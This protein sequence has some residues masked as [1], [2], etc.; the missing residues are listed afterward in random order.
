MG[1]LAVA[2]LALAGPVA[3]AGALGLTLSTGGDGV[4][5]DFTA[6]SN[7]YEVPAQAGSTASC[8][9]PALQQV[10]AAFGDE[11]DYFL[12]PGGAFEGKPAGWSLGSAGVSSGN[13]P[14]YLRSRYDS[15]SLKIPAGETVTSAPI[16]VDLDH[17]SFRMFVRGTIVSDLTGALN[18]T[19][20]LDV[21]VVYADAPGSPTRTV[22]RIHTPSK[23]KVTPDIALLPEL[24]GE[25]PGWR[26]VRLRF[27]APLDT[28]R[29][30]DLYIDP[31]HRG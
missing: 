22:G 26:L 29:I 24:G 7:D 17:P 23:W 14:W 10:F 2:A 19:T 30:D 12:A 21:K 9:R 3:Q 6:A 11:K 5:A 16:C 28:V 27:T 1:L 13:E 18:V 31:R 20:P 4:T 25:D 15:S 8:S